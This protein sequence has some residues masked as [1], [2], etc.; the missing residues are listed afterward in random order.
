MKI[1]LAVADVQWDLITAGGI[2]TIIPVCVM[3]FFAQKTVV[4]GLTAGAVKG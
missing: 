2:I 3:F 1:F 4:S